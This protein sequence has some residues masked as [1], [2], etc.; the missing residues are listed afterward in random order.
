[1]AYDRNN[2]MRTHPSMVRLRG[3]IAFS[4]TVFGLLFTYVM[5]T[6]IPIEDTI[7][8]IQDHGKGRVMNFVASTP[9]ANVF[10]A[11]RVYGTV[12]DV[13]GYIE[14]LEQDHER[15]RELLIRAQ[16]EPTPANIYA[17]AAHLLNKSDVWRSAT[18]QARRH[19]HDAIP[20]EQARR[21]F[22]APMPPLPAA[23][24]AQASGAKLSG[25]F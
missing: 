12:N 21:I 14:L 2:P 10:P 23:N 15:I 3:F 8:S 13:K 20:M 9:L 22:L 7:Q 18:A 1:M 17:A 24:A 4:A 19:V 5:T 16:I 25:L 11:V 6:S